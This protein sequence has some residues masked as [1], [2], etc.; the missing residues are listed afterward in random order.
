ME[1]DKGTI[2]Q[3]PE[4]LYHYT[5]PRGLLGIAQRKN[6]WVSN[7]R[8]LNDATEFLHSVN[9]ASGLVSEMDGV[10]FGAVAKALKVNPV[11]LFTLASHKY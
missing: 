10:E 9:L 3:T 5:T 8:F 11:E 2:V 1:S 6:L 4:W 7:T